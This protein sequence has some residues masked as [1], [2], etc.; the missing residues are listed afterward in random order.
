MSVSDGLP[1][2]GKNTPSVLANLF[3]S[4]VALSDSGMKTVG[5]VLA[6]CFGPKSPFGLFEF[7]SGHGLLPFG[8]Y[9]N[10][11]PLVPSFLMCG[12]PLALTLLRQSP[13][14][15]FCTTPPVFFSGAKGHSSALWP[16]PLQKWHLMKGHSSL[17]CLVLP[18]IQ[19]PSALLSEPLLIREYYR[20]CK[21]VCLFFLLWIFERTVVHPY[22]SLFFNRINKQCFFFPFLQ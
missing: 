4:S 3:F 17:E 2:P 18:Q 1:W 8:L 11:V 20:M 15:G 10:R 21:V 19:H 13:I 12:R 22:C 16:S 9:S 7:E 5:F 6:G 14:L